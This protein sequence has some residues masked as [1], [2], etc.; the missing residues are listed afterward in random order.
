ML[1]RIGVAMAAIAP[2]AAVVGTA[3]KG[4]RSSFQSSHSFAK[5]LR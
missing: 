4:G 1:Q 3:Q 2:S 5:L